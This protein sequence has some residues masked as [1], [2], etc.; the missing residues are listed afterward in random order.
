GPHQVPAADVRQGRD[1]GGRH[2]RGGR[3]LVPGRT[4][5]SISDLDSDRP[6][7]TPRRRRG[8]GRRRRRPVDPFR[9]GGGDGSREAQLVGDM[10]FD[11]Y[12][13]R[14]VV[15]APPWRGPIAAY[16]FL[17]GLAGGSGLLALGG[18]LT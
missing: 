16:L 7:E 13:G 1:R 11:S 5:V 2:G 3:A 9:A 12:Y 8:G 10:Q 14:Q 4:P 15:K 17:G 6:P 18:Q